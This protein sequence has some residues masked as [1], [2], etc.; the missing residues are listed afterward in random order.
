MKSKSKVLSYQINIYIF[1]FTG[2]KHFFDYLRRIGSGS[3]DQFLKISDKPS[4][5][6]TYTLVNIGNKKKQDVFNEV[7]QST[8]DQRF[9]FVHGLPQDK[10]V[11]EFVNAVFV[12]LLIAVTQKNFF[13]AIGFLVF[14]GISVR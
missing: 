2:S 13:R 6:K 1:N 14:K 12:W 11:Q 4:W 7:Q 8:F 9:D 3:V 5:N 10:N